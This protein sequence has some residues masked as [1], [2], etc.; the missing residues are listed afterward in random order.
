VDHFDHR[1]KRL[2]DPEPPE[3][4]PDEGRMIVR[5]PGAITTIYSWCE[6][7]SYFRGCYGQPAW[8][9][10]SMLEPACDEGPVGRGN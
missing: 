10:P 7:C 2:D 6:H 3:R 4:G 9:G 1:G 5:H 8:P